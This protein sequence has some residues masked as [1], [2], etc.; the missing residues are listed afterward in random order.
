MLKNVKI[1]NFKIFEEWTHLSLVAEPKR[2]ANEE[3]LNKFNK[4]KILKV[5]AILGPNS[6]GKTTFME[7]IQFI[8]LLLNRSVFNGTLSFLQ[9]RRKSALMNQFQNETKDFLLVDI[10]K[11]ID[12][13]VERHFS[14]INKPFE[15]KLEFENKKGNLKAHVIF[16]PNGEIYEKVDINGDVKENKQ[17]IDI[18]QSILFSNNEFAMDTFPLFAIDGYGWSTFKGVKFDYELF[19]SWM[20]IADPKISEFSFNNDGSPAAFKVK[21]PITKKDSNFLSIANMSQGTQKWMTF[22]TVLQLMKHSKKPAIVLFDELDIKL[23]QSLS[24]FL[25]QIFLNKKINKNG[26]QLIFT[27]HNPNTIKDD[28]RKDAINYIEGGKFVNVGNDLNLR[29]DFSFSKNYTNEVVGNHPEFE[30]R[31]DFIERFTSNE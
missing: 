4:D 27:S 28:F 3:M 13:I 12:L 19:K 16:Y 17:K 6:S 30:Y 25:I 31:E 18:F 9:S 21:M 1:K 29:N 20:K 26:S 5:S 23:H 11:A 22:Y 14:D 8:W 7:G 24:D 2:T 10:Q 15:A